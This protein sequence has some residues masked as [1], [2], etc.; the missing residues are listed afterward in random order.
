MTVLRV[1]QVRPNR[2]GI[3]RMSGAPFMQAE[4]RRRMEKARLLAIA[5]A[6]VDTGLYLSRFLRTDAVET[7]RKPN[8]AAYARLSNDARDPRSGFCYALALEVG[9]EHMRAQ[10]ILRRALRAVED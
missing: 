7:G 2:V 10:R 3:R 1:K 8:G 9:T 6:P 5:I 4:M